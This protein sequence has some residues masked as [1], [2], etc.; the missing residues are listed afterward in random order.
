MSFGADKVSSSDLVTIPKMFNYQGKLTNLT[1]NPVS[2][3]TYSVTFRL[4]AVSSSGSSFW[5]ETQN[6]TTHAGLFNVLLGSTTQIDSI[7]QSGNCYLEMQLNPNPAMTPRVRLVSSAYAYFAQ[8]ADTAS[9]SISANVVYV[10]SARIAT[11]AYKLQGNDTIALSAKYVDEGQVNAI[12]NIMIVD[13]AVTSIKIQD[14]AITRNDVTNTFKAP[15]SDTADYARAVNVQ[16]V[17]SARISSNSYKL[18]GKDTI[19]LSAKFIDEGQTNAISS[20]MIVDGAVSSAKILDASIIRQDVANNF[21]APYSDTS[22]YVRNVNIQYVDSSRIATNAHNAY[23]LQGKDT[24]ALDVRY[25]NEGQV[26]SISSGMII[27]GTISRQD[28]ASNFKAP[29][30]DTADYTRYAPGAIDSARVAANSHKLQGK[31]TTALDS[32]YINESEINSI[33]SEMIADSTITR[34][35]VITN[36]KAPYSDTADFA[37]LAPAVDSATVA[38]N[39]HKLQGKDTTALDTK[40]VNEGQSNSITTG[41]IRDSAV[42]NTKLARNSVTTDKILDGTIGANDIEDGA[43]TNDKMDRDAVTTNEILDRT[44]IRADV[45]TNF[46]APYADTADFARGTNANYVDSARITTNAHKLQGKDTIALSVKFVDEGQTNAITTAMIAD[47]AVTTAKIKAGAITNSKLGADAVTGDKIQNGTITRNDV[48]STFKAPYADTCDYALSVNIQYIDSARVAA[49]AYKLQGKDTTALSSKFVD[50]GQTNAIYSAMIQNNAVTTVKIA[51]T[52]I[53]M[54]KIQRA[55]ATTG[56]ILKWTGSTWA[57]RTDSATGSPIGPASGD[58][59]ASY[60]NPTIAN[61]AVSSVKILDGSIKGVDIAKPC[62][63]EA[64]ASLV[65]QEVKN[66]NLK[67]PDI[68]AVLNVK[69]NGSGDGIKVIDA[70]RDGVNVNHANGAGVAVANAEMDGFNVGTAGGAGLYIYQTN[71]QGIYIDSTNSDGI[72]I[73]HANLSGIYINRA[74]GEGIYVDSAGA[75]GVNVNHTD[76]DGFYVDHAA[77]NGVSVLNA[78]E[79]GVYAKGDTAGGELIANNATAVGVRAH[80]YSNNANDTAIYAYGKVISTGGFSEELTV[81]EGYPI[82]SSARTIIAY[83]TSTLSNGATEIIYPEIFEKNIQS[84][85]PVRISLTPRGDPAGILCLS[86]TKVDGF[87]VTLKRIIG[88]SGDDNFP[89]DWIA[90]GTLKEPETS[91]E[92]KAEWE[93]MMKKVEAAKDNYLKK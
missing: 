18:Q 67:L 92:A 24:T 66:S 82:V 50:E 85:I 75:V 84:D 77:F 28:V 62:T 1:G 81:G 8:K 87:R 13:N 93:K 14:N 33:N 31:D 12:S 23:K 41:M 21:K 3:S 10:D 22:D 54:V 40:Y 59:T 27:D 83:G 6:V 44:I 49:N 26:N 39:A 4:F 53:T 90:V 30:A 9:Y 68:G 2:D 65:E 5:N 79:C 52:N 69:N 58:L 47:S 64:S 37:R 15:Y 72:Y 48:A 36:F 29:L 42:T 89:F 34:Q 91:P 35:D 43:I 55:G 60:P 46:K 63:L 61:N 20:G 7:P 16:Y 88:W 45:A 19:A 32:R 80:S 51:D 71:E 86:E 73:N 17:D 11:N 74:I 25:I 76:A 56:Q 38:A 70:G 57:P 78:G